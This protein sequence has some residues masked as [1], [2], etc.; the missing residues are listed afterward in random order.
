MKKFTILLAVIIALAFFGSAMAVSSGKTV[1]FKTSMGTVTFDGKTHAE[2]GLK[3]MDCHPKTFQMKKGS[4]KMTEADHVP[5]KLCGACHDG[6][7]AFAQTKE[8]CNKCHKKAAG[9][10]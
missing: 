8:N 3:C 4:F 9:G 10:Y 7:K 1:E 5:G 2:K 6:T